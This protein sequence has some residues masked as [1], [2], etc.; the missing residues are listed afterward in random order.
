MR[1]KQKVRGYL[2][3]KLVRDK[4]SKYF[5][6]IPKGISTKGVDV[7]A[8]N[9]Y[10]AIVVE[11]KSFN[12]NYLTIKKQQLLNLAKEEE[13][14]KHFLGLKTLKLLAIIKGKRFKYLK[15]DEKLLNQIE[16]S[17]KITGKSFENL[18]DF[19]YFLLLEELEEKD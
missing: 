3:E 14:I 5:Y 18:K 10:F 19:D 12:G 1:I 11:V 17:L 7:V 16:D 4:L 6:I 8:L 9:K 15:V 2:A 13:K